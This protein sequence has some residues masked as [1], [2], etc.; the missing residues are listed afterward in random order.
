M[1]HANKI[2]IQTLLKVL[3]IVILGYGSET[4]SKRTK[5]HRN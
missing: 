2:S 3:F 1:Q 4:Q 5:L